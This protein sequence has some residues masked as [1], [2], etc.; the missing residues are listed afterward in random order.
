MAATLLE[1]LGRDFFRDAPA[2]PDTALPFASVYL[3]E[4]E[5]ALELANK[6]VHGVLHLGWVPDEERGGYRGEMAVWVKPNG[7]AGKAY[8]GAIKPFRYTIVYPAL[9]RAFE[10]RWREA[11][12]G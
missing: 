8:M 4:N 9:M 12:A 7:L 5:W 6:T 1:R 10:R 2:A 3:V 11:S